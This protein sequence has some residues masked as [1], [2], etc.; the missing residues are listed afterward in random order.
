MAE[1]GVRISFL[2]NASEGERVQYTSYIGSLPIVYNNGLGA[3][4]FEFTNNDAEILAD[5]LHRVKIGTDAE[6]TAINVKYFFENNGYTVS[7]I[8]VSYRVF[9]SG[10]I[11]NVESVFGTD[12][13]IYFD[14]TMD[15]TNISM[16]AYFS[17]PIPKTAPKY[18]FQYKNI[19]NEEY[20]V[21]IY[22]NNFTGTTTEIS[23]RATI[24][25]GEVKN[26]FDPIRGT[27]L[28]LQ[29]EASNGL[30]FSDL[31]S[32][33]ERDFQVRMY[34]DLQLIFQGFVKAD[35][36][37]ESFTDSIWNINLQCV[38]GLGFLDNM[39]F[40]KSNGSR[41]TG[42][43]SILDVLYNCLNRTGLQLKINTYVN[44]FY[45]G[46]VETVESDPLADIM[47][48]TDRFIKADDNT[49]MSCK[50][51]M[52]S[53][54]LNAVVTQ[55]LGEWHI[56]R[57]SDF[58]KNTY[59][60]FKRY[61][62]DNTYIGLRQVNL[63]RTLGSQIDNVYPHHCNKN[64]MIQIQGSVSSFKL[65]YKYGFIDS[66]TGNG[67]LKHNPGSIV[68]DGWTVQTWTQNTV[69]GFLVIDPVSEFGISF[70]AGVGAIGT[71]P[72]A[73]RLNRFTELFTGTTINF[74]AR[75]ISNG[76]PVVTY[77]IVIVGSYYLNQDGSWTS[78]P[79]EIMFNT[80]DVN[81]NAT[82]ELTD[83]VF[84][85]TNIISSA[86]IPEDGEV[87]II[88]KVPHKQSNLG[89]APLSQIKS[90][91]LIN[92]Y[93]GDNVV[94]EFHNV[95]RSIAP[96]SIVKEN[97]TRLN[98]DSYNYLYTGAFYM[99][100]GEDLTEKWHRGLFPLETS[101]EVKPVLRI[102]AE[103][104]LRIAQKPLVLFSGDV[105]GYIGY[106]SVI[107]INGINGVFMP[108]AF[109]FDTYSNIGTVKSLELFYEELA[110]IRYEKQNDY[111]ETVKPTIVS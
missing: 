110:D 27:G 101:Q 18:F 84:E 94:G 8:P 35:G 76:F 65:G 106:L 10:T 31:Y 56:Y 104:E 21:E 44:L 87:Q 49:I 46:M 34:R 41:F 48:N 19:V 40:T 5:P 30:T 92:T 58:Y 2:N 57:P 51:V 14:M 32:T 22:Q 36:I 107:K 79:A 80:A 96:S 6:Q 4:D 33:D 28:N 83:D 59:P 50:E 91:E 26:H 90:I 15:G 78:S 68:Y 97:K 109:E 77:F 55:E 24:I 9:F 1:Q 98:G 99:A 73:L 62:I 16:V 3:V 103:D 67:N 81:P 70:K 60:F 13:V 89:L 45:Y 71:P 54:L 102:L 42:K 38:D 12:D 85:K 88:A 66:I 7:S 52:E 29:L 37:F 23:G 100:N 63:N 53:L 17:N 82:G 47:I 111:G 74:K 93:Q 39:A 86:P 25:K 108:I 11:W 61:E 75:A 95:T 20:K 72:I 69:N 64:Q 43:M 105:F